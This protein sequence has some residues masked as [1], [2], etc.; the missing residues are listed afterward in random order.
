MP[1]PAVLRRILAAVAVASACLAGFPVAAQKNA[2][3]DVPS[4]DPA[5]EAAKA[6]ARAGL[7]EFWKSFE[8]PGPGEDRF[9][10]KVSVPVGGGNTEHIWV[11]G[12]ER[13][14]DG[15]IAARLDNVPRD[16]K[17]KKS[18]DR[19]EI[20]T[21]DISD[22][23]FMRN[24]KIVGNETMRPLLAR[25]PKAQADHYRAMLEKP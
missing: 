24:G 9:T 12:I 7:A 19:I 15:R 21:K 1:F 11:N 10:L 4:T 5:M 14:P 3:I 17:G 23:M 20:E 2:V 16:M 13:L 18:G 25:L 8:K 22:W 6:K